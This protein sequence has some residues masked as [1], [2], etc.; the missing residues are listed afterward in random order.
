MWHV[1]RHRERDRTSAGRRRETVRRERQLHTHACSH[2]HSTTSDKGQ[3]TQHSRAPALDRPGG[4][5]VCKTHTQTSFVRGGPG[6]RAPYGPSGFTR[7]SRSRTVSMTPSSCGDSIRYVTPPSKAPRLSIPTILTW[8]APSDRELYLHIG[9][10]AW[11]MRVSWG[12]TMHEGGLRAY[13]LHARGGGSRPASRTRR[14][15]SCE[16]AHACH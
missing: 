10:G 1:H 15:R 7:D 4:R 16:A 13:E 12:V 9:K 11:S 2:A 3:G 8:I 14:T 6:M 5:A